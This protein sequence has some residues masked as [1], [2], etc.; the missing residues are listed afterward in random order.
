MMENF[1]VEVKQACKFYDVLG[2]DKNL[3]NEYQKDKE[4]FEQIN[5]DNKKKQKKHKKG[6]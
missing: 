6:Y 1:S 4:S 5:L 2:G 3:I